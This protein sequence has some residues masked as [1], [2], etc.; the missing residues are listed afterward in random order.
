MKTGPGKFCKSPRFTV[1]IHPFSASFFRKMLN[2][3][4]V[5]KEQIICVCL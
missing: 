4:G 5:D 3:N 2:I 1:D